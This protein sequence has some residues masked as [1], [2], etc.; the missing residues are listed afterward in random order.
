MA[1]AR[2]LIV[3]DEELLLNAMSRMLS[4]AAYEVLSANRPHQALEIIRKEAPIDLVISDI[5]MP[6]MR[7][8]ELIR[9]IA[10]ISPRTARLLIAGGFVDSEEVPEDVLVL[11]K[12]FSATE[13]IS[14]AG[15]VLGRCAQIGAGIAL[16]KSVKKS[17]REP[18]EF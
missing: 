6:E 8:P 3:D 4:M 12:P 9:E 5:A 10:R 17:P 2:V 14:T 11:S 13:L 1:A 15:A 7:G 18:E 16:G